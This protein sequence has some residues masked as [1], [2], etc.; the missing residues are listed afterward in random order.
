MLE[1]GLRF[2]DAIFIHCGTAGSICP[3]GK[4]GNGKT[5]NRYSGARISSLHRIHVAKR[6]F[7][8][9]LLVQS[10]RLGADAGWGYATPSTLT[11]AGENQVSDVAESLAASWISRHAEHLSQGNGAFSNSSARTY[12]GIN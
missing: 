10:G 1:W 11:G 9:P 3:S 2:E 7:V 6:S 4:T 8:Y 12:I 5:G